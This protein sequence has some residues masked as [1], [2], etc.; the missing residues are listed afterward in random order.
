[1]IS[2]QRVSD[3]QPPTRRPA[4]NYTLFQPLKTQWRSGGW[5]N[6]EDFLLSLLFF[7]FISPPLKLWL[8][9][10]QKPPPLKK[11]ALI[12]GSRDAPSLPP[13]RAP[14]WANLWSRTRNGILKEW[15]ETHPNKSPGITPGHSQS[16]LLIVFALWKRVSTNYWRSKSHRE[17]ACWR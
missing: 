12:N 7:F 11:K 10:E 9:K 3:T 16:L 17:E 2:W 13:F 4:V 6:T 1:M 15:M 14:Q 5:S 8:L